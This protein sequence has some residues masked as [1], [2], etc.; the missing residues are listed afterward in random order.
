MHIRR[1]KPSDWAEWLR[2]SRALFPG[3]IEEDEKEM[4]QTLARPDAAVI[5]L[6][7]DGEKAL[8]GYVEVGSRS[9]VD[10]CS[11]SPVGYI[12]AW[13]VDPDARRAGHGRDLLQAA[14]QWARDQGYTEMGSDA[15]IDNLVSHEAHKRSGY[16]E[17]DRVVTFRKSLM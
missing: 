3:L 13:Y 4:R 1:Y 11:T 5:V 9:V 2:M 12:E 10:G 7:R 15:L 16:V 17:I 8:A 6:E 14:E